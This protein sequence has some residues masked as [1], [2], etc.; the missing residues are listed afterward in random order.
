MGKRVLRSFL[1]FFI[2][3]VI[4]IDIIFFFV[5]FSSEESEGSVCFDKGCFDIEVADEASERINGLMGREELDKDSG[6]LFVFDREE[7]Q[8]FWMKNTLISL[9]IIWIDSNNRVVYIKNDALPCEDNCEIYFS[10]ESALYVF[11]INAGMAKEFGIDV[12]EIAEI[13]F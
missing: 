2:L 10:N 3:L 5:V 8:G 6:M 1:G 11:E 13:N 12:G 4:I 9:D 7:V